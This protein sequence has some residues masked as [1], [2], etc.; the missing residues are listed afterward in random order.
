MKEGVNLQLRQLQEVGDQ[1]MDCPMPSASR[2][3]QDGTRMMREASK[4]CVPVGGRRSVECWR[5]TELTLQFCF[6][7]LI[8]G[9]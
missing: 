7:F 2:K 6:H 4:V 5:K 3:A 9:H 1:S 8:I